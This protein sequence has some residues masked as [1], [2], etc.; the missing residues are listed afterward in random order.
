MS[1]QSTQTKTS[2]A[3]SSSAKTVTLND[4][5]KLSVPPSGGNFSK[6]EIRKAVRS[7]LAQKP[8]KAKTG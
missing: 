2:P 7:A 4:G 6:T 8:R 3:R 1:K 5:R